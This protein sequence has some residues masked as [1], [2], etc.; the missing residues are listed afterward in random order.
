MCR[1]GTASR[2]YQAEAQ[3]LIS[4]SS[5]QT[6]LS[7]VHCCLRAAIACRCRLFGLRSRFLLGFG[8]LLRRRPRR[9]D[10]H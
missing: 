10:L 1:I 7:V 4:S 2:G 8:F 9:S 6:A 5:F 3:R